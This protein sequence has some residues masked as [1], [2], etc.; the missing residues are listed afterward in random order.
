MKKG[1]TLIEL[2]AVIIILSIVL[3]VA[4]M[5]VADILNDSKKKIIGN[6]KKIN[7]KCS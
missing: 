3:L 4:S 5:S 7:R 1:F 2:M 6:T